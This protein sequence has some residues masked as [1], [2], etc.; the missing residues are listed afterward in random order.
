MAFALFSIRKMWRSVKA[1]NVA[2]DR[3]GF[4]RVD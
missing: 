1:F 4:A 2:Y 3:A